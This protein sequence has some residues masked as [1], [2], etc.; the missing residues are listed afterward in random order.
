MKSLLEIGRTFRELRINN[1]I[2]LKQASD[3]NVSISQLSRFERGQADLSISKFIS[4]LKNIQ[5]E[6]G[7]FFSALNGHQKS[8][9]IEFMSKLSKLEYE[10]DIE[11][12]R[13]LYKEQK[14]KYS[15]NPSV[16]QYHLNMILAQSF[17]CKCDRSIPFPKEYEREIADY[18]F[19]TDEWN[20]YEL[21][22]IGNI[23]MFIDIPLLHKMGTEVL[24]K[25]TKTGANKNLATIVLLNIFETCVYRNNKDV[26]TYY[27]DNIPALISDETKLYER[28]LYHFLLGMYTYKWEDKTRGK[29]IMEEAI[30]IYDYLGCINLAKNYRQDMTDYIIT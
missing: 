4:A 1:H 26:A 7:E 19:V 3:E 28:N 22:L 27:K 8:E 17:I 13:S 24:D 6:P 15:S 11:G 21:I 5:T 25:V 20:I 9:T 12:F 10:R 2:S 29:E 18:L 14:E 23:Y 16:Y 30:K